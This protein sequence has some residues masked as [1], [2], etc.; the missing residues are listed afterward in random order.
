M[1]ASR[2]REVGGVLVTRRVVA[3]PKTAMSPF[4]ARRSVGHFVADQRLRDDAKES[5]E[6]IASEL[7]TNAVTHGAEPVVLSVS[8]EDSE[9]T[10]EV[11]DG[12]P[13]IDEVRLR[14]VD[15]PALG[16]RGLRLVASLADQWG[17]RRTRSG[18]AIWASKAVSGAG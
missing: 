5:L 7:V 13:R 16:G 15:K 17:I 18:K 3:L 9:V 1:L 4:L 6:L 2:W 8:C 11:A 14:D 10:I 12:D